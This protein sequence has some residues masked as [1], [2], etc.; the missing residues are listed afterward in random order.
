MQIELNL[1]QK[2]RGDFW[3]RVGNRAGL[4]VWAFYGNGAVRGRDLADPAFAQE[5]MRQY[6][7]AL[8]RGLWLCRL[9]ALQWDGMAVARAVGESLVQTV[10][11]GSYGLTD[12]EAG[13]A[14][15]AL[16]HLQA[17][18]PQMVQEALDARA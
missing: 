15:E 1:A 16:R 5:A 3:W 14:E 13:R 10:V 4:M 7:A 12:L 2:S 11:D 18:A 9:M 6:R 17:L 8:G